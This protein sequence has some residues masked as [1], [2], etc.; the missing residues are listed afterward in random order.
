[1][2]YLGSIKI[3]KYPLHRYL[4][5]VSYIYHYQT[6]L[7]PHANRNS[8]LDHLAAGQNIYLFTSPR[9]GSTWLSQLLASIP[10]S[11]ILWEPLF[12]GGRKYKELKEVGFDWHQPIPQDA[13]WPEAKAFFKKLLNREILHAKLL[14]IND[15]R[16]VPEAEI[17]IYKFCYGNL[18]L[19]W[20]IDHF[21]IRPILFL[22]HPCAVVASQLK[23]GFTKGEWTYYARNCRYNEIFKQHE[24]LFRRITQPEQR[25]A[26]QWAIEMHYLL[27]HPYHNKKWLTVTY[28][29]MVLNPGR[30]I[31]RVS[32]W[33]NMPI[34]LPR[35]GTIRTPSAT[36]DD[37]SLKRIKSPEEQLSSWK[38][39]LS[40]GQIYN[41]LQV[42][43]EYFSLNHYTNTPM[44]NRELLFSVKEIQ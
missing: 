2:K 18:M 30:E 31:E 9:G 24:A 16:K 13:D 5:E 39:E 28:E 25:L 36:T 42:V 40:P 21:G 15:L 41:V 27:N 37:G 8:K 14:W 44:P 29:E 7:K 22:R 20:L 43:N 6:R 12:V 3:G 32:N 23:R 26:A 19:P 38:K 1:M 17:F 35:M 10:D 33:I 4:K 11:A 34:I